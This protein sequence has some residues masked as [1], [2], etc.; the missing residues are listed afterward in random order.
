MSSSS[1][2]TPHDLKNVEY[3][4]PPLIMRKIFEVECG[5]ARLDQQV[6]FFRYRQVLNDILATLDALASARIAGIRT[7]FLDVYRE[8]E[9]RALPDGGGEPE[10]DGKEAFAVNK[11]LAFKRC[12]F[13][14]QRTMGQQGATVDEA[15][16]LGLYDELNGGRTGDG[17]EGRVGYRSASLSDAVSPDGKYVLY[18]PP[19]SSEIPG[20]MR[21]LIAFCNSE[22]AG[23]FV[24]SVVAHLTFE[25]IAPFDYHMDHMG[26]LICQSIFF[27]RGLFQHMICP[28]AL[29]AAEQPD[30]HASILFPYRNRTSTSTA[31]SRT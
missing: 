20:L 15:F 22:Y 4:A 31:T 28:I 12:L 17:A 14:V 18:T 9:R 5:L 3:Y 2:F 23:A 26:R 7:S 24:Q 29:L 16:V 25:G 27:R 11:V 30:L 13:K 10:P 6:F 1:A 8:E 19:A 21:D